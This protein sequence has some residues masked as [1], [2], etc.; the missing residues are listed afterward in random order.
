MPNGITNDKR[1]GRKFAHW[2]KIVVSLLPTHRTI[3]QTRQYRNGTIAVCVRMYFTTER[4]PCHAMPCHTISGII[5]HRHSFYKYAVDWW[6]TGAASRV[7]WDWFAFWF[8]INSIP[9]KLSQTCSPTNGFSGFFFFSFSFTCIFFAAAATIA[10]CG[11]YLWH[12]KAMNFNYL[13]HVGWHPCRI[14]FYFTKNCDIISPTDRCRV[15][16]ETAIFKPRLQTLYNWAII[17]KWVLDH[18]VHKQTT[19]TSVQDGIWLISFW[20]Y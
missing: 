10:V 18:F 5:F 7:I 6:L 4:V 17:S 8:Q 9:L 1:K 20:P 16:Y 14:V 15:L 13:L 2:V 11:A 19:L 12:I 3:R